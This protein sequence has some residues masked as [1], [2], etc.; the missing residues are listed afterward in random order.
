VISNR[1]VYSRGNGFEDFLSHQSSINNDGYPNKKAGLPVALFCTDIHQTTI[2][3]FMI[4]GI[5]KQ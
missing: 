4:M 2:I 5:I 1:P 3:L